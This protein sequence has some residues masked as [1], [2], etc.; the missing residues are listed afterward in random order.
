MLGR[1]IHH[2]HI[3]DILSEGGYGSIYR[4]MNT[5]TQQLV[6][7]KIEKKESLKNEKEIYQLLQ[8]EPGFP[9]LLDSIE[10]PMA[11]V[12][13]LLGDSLS[14]ILLKR[15]IFS[16]KTT[17]Q[18]GL[19]MLERVRVIHE[20]GIIHYDI[21]PSNFV[22]GLDHKTIYLIDF[23]LSECYINNNQHRHGYQVDEIK[24]TYQYSSRHIHNGMVG[25]RRDDL[26][27]WIYILIKMQCGKL[28]WQH[29]RKNK[30]V[31]FMK[32]KWTAKRL[33]KSLPLAFYTLLVMIKNLGYKQTPN[34]SLLKNT[35]IQCA[36]D[37]HL[38]LDDDYDWS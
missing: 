7:I 37:H 32:R 15:K 26:E 24:G 28:P 4:A 1:T 29:L 21:K 9:M 13:P 19:Q 27:S 33:T 8:N 17:L 2:Y 5:T 3:V 35:L 14:Q 6:V 18:C 12:L 16:L 25:S 22:L 34:Y 31:L 30:E 36:K 23:G 10:Q 38:I 20:H 11:I